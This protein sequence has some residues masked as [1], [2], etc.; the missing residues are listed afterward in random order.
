M[1]PLKDNLRCDSPA[2]ITKWLILA[3]VVAFIFELT[4]IM[5]GHQAQFFGTWLM[6]PAKVTAAFSAGDPSLM[7]WATITIFASMFLHGSFGHIFGNMIFLF[8]FGKA[9]ENRLGKGKYLAFYLLTGV[10]AAMT[11]YASDPTSMVP[12]LGASGAIAGVLG[13]Y[14]L[15]WPRATISGFY[16]VPAPAYVHTEAYW[17]LIGWF[18]MQFSGVLSSVG[19]VSA[20]PGG[21]HSA[22]QLASDG[23]AY[24]AHIGG[25]VSGFILAGIAKLAMPVS[26]VCIIP[27]PACEHE[28]KHDE[29]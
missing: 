29:K 20:L 24:W 17:F 13:G 4:A 2:T 22:V 5:S 14:L 27:K 23:V 9:M 28:D 18:V 26:S 21:A 1:F 10:V 6:V 12:T 8:I 19:P 16:V 25:F 3:N 7:F 11:H 15:F